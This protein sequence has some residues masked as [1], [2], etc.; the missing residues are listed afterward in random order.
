MDEG[1]YSG[2][3]WNYHAD[4]GGHE[5]LVIRGRALDVHVDCI[6]SNRE[7][8]PISIEALPPEMR[9]VAVIPKAALRRRVTR[10]GKAQIEG[11]IMQ[12][13][14]RMTVDRSAT[15]HEP[16]LRSGD[17]IEETSILSH[18]VLHGTTVAL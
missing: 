13:T 2:F 8:S 16:L 10:R 14:S 12:S 1:G 3:Q 5:G 18:E 6:F 4:L 9:N 17:S 15:N 7:H 11:I